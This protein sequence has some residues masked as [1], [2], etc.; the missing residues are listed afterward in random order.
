MKKFLL[1]LVNLVGFVFAQSVVEIEPMLGS[2]DYPRSESIRIGFKFGELIDTSSKTVKLP[3]T[4][5]LLWVSRT[6]FAD[7]RAKSVPYRNDSS[8]ESRPNFGNLVLE[9]FEK[10]ANI[11]QAVLFFEGR[12]ERP[13]GTLDL[14]K[15]KKQFSDYSVFIDKNNTFSEKDIVPTGTFQS[16]QG[17]YL[18]ENNIV[19]CRFL[20]L[21]EKNKIIEKIAVNFINTGKISECPLEL[22]KNDKIIDI[23]PS[24]II[25][26]SVG[27]EYRYNSNNFKL[28][29]TSYTDGKY[30]VNYVNAES[31]SRFILEKISNLAD[32]YKLNKYMLVRNIKY[33]DKMKSIFPSWNFITDESDI[34]WSNLNSATIFVNKKA[35]ISSSQIFFGADPETA[36][37]YRIETLFKEAQR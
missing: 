31:A 5:I 29:R 26:S 22:I 24:S 7:N 32:K 1:L 19:R 15:V 9:F 14:S 34:L 18:V 11:P 8:K 16:Q 35:K 20:S 10:K 27:N 3:S 17:L 33:I 30:D 4:R 21:S 12:N 28:S 25:F 36:D 23:K 13:I 6:D 2:L 37:S